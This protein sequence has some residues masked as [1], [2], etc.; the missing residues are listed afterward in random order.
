MTSRLQQYPINEYF[1]S[2]SLFQFN[3]THKFLFNTLFLVQL[4][5][6]HSTLLYPSVRL[7]RFNI[8]L[9]QEHILRSTLFTFHLICY[10]FCSTLP[11][12]PLL[13]IFLTP[14][15]FHSR[16]VSFCKRLLRRLECVKNATFFFLRRRKKIVL[17][18]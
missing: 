15:Q 6:L 11:P 1:N 5:I 2:K 8:F 7:L 17:I 13:F 18:G 16:R 3:S 12:F 10:F 14:S 4:S 9:F